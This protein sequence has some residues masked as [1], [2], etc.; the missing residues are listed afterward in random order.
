MKTIT[1]RLGRRCLVVL[2]IVMFVGSLSLVNAKPY[3]FE[4]YQQAVEMLEDGKADQASSILEQLVEEYPQP[5]TAL[6]IPGNRFIDYLPYFQQARAK[7]ELGDVKSATEKLN[8]A[9]SYGAL[10]ES[11]RHVKEHEELRTSI[12]S[13]RQ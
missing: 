1:H 3:W 7:L 4:E 8:K 13:K 9:E 6:R 12:A 2:F 5:I 10:T 11:D